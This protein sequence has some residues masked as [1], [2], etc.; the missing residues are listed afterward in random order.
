MFSLSRLGIDEIDATFFIMIINIMI[1]IGSI[2]LGIYLIRL[3]IR[4]LKKNS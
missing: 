3:L 2:V 1:I 4:Y